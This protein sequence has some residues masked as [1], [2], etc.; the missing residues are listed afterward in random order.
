MGQSF[1]DA[2]GCQRY[3]LFIVDVGNSAF[4]HIGHYAEHLAGCQFLTGLSFLIGDISDLY[5][6][7]GI[8]SVVLCADVDR[9]QHCQ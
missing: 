3:V 7:D 9:C 2:V 8:Q 4:H 6:I 5:L 1:L